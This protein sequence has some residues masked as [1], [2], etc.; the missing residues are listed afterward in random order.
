MTFKRF[1][2]GLECGHN[3]VLHGLDFLFGHVFHGNL[4]CITQIVCSS[5]F[6]FSSNN[7]LVPF[8]LK[9]G[10]IVTKFFDSVSKVFRTTDDFILVLFRKRDQFFLF[11]NISNTTFTAF[12]ELRNILF[13]TTICTILHQVGDGFTALMAVMELRSCLT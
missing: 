1:L 3:L 13:S 5:D 6:L 11:W 9:I 2:N 10:F 8:I 4:I 12:K 7:V